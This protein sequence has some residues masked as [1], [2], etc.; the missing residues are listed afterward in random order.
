MLRHEKMGGLTTEGGRIMIVV[1]RIARF[2]N[3]LFTFAT[4]KSGVD[5]RDRG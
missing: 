4:V 2:V 1:L 3:V 5:G